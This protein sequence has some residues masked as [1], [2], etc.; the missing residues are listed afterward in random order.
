MS[1]NDP[2]TI[3]KNQPTEVSAMT[4]KM[5]R[6]KAQELQAKTRKKLMGT[7]AGPAA[8]AFFA[9]FGMKSFASLQLQPLFAIA[10]LWSI[11]GMYFLNRQLWSTAVSEDMGF[12]AGLESC[13]REVERQRSL[14]GRLLLWS[15]GPVL[16]ALGAVILA[17]T[18]VGSADRKVFSN[19]LPFLMVVCLWIVGYFV[20]R[21]REKRELQR[22]ADE[23]D[24]IEA[25]SHR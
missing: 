11:V 1:S 6:R 13:R 15:F 9:I 20:V 23:L 8:V 10:F 24:E 19:V 18:M 7:L 2:K 25:E 14:L 5:I 4:L 21:L 3:W 22:E 12:S 17:L 16:L